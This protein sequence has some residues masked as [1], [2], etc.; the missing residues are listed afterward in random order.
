M[1]TR[2]ASV[3]R[4]WNVR[5]IGP[6]CAGKLV[7]KFGENIFDVIENYSARLEKSGIGPERRRRIKAAGRNRKWC[8]GISGLPPRFQQV[9]TSRAVRI[10]KT[11]GERAIETLK[12]ILRPGQ[13]I[14]GIGF[15][16]ATK[17]HK[18]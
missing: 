3:S 18:K 11:Y 15:R 12:L 2:K 7:S 17:L 6:K 13:D 1:T 10:Y 4:Q 16:T 14:R 8:A 5:G 9:G